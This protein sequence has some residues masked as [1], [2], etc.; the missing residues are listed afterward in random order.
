MAAKVQSALAVAQTATVDPVGM[1]QFMSYFVSALQGAW[2][3]MATRTNAVLPKDGSE[4]LTG[5]L[6]LATYTVAGLPTAGTAGRKAYVSDGAASIAWG[7]TVTGGGST[8]Y[9]V[10][11]NGVHWT[12]AGK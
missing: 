10:W 5:P 8:K 1:A 6:Q 4:A 9:M 7:A 3:N 11:D 2:A 12:V